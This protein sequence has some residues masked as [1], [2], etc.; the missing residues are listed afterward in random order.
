MN[1]T[2]NTLPWL[3]AASVALAVLGLGGLAWGWFLMAQRKIVR[4]QRFSRMEQ[5]LSSDGA[6]PDSE[7]LTA[8]EKLVLF[9]SGRLP[10]GA[11]ADQDS[12]D[13]L[14]L[15]RAGWR[16]LH[17][18]AL[19]HAVRWLAVLGALLLFGGYALVAGVA[20]GWLKAM[21]LAIAAFLAPRYG[22]RWLA[23]RRAK[24][25]RDELPVFV[26]F[27]RMMHSV[28][29][30]FEQ[31]ISVFA[32][33]SRLGLPLLSSELAMVSLSIRSGR[34]RGEALQLMAHQLDIDDLNEL[35]ALICHTDYYGAAVQE[36]LRQFSA[37]LTERKRFEM[38]DYVGKMATRMVVVMVLFLL[39]ALIIVTAGPAFISV[40]KALG[41]MT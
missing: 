33:D 32:N 40:F 34:S 15:I 11:S 27:L 2:A 17:A 37:R 29:I 20:S 18:L 6:G 4:R 24:K 5:M 8:P 23:A 22:L 3:I 28:G 31:S 21:A 16:S 30:N 25:L 1:A 35:V 13:R 38:Q 36:P 9:F 19:F 39:P 7:D 14:L 12:E 41:G 26:D 10:G